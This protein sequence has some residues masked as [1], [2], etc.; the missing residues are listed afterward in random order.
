MQTLHRWFVLCLALSVFGLIRC[1]LED[2][3]LDQMDND[4]F[5]EIVYDS[6]FKTGSWQSAQARVAFNGIPANISQKG[7]MLAIEFRT[8]TDHFRLLCIEQVESYIEELNDG[9]EVKREMRLVRGR[10]VDY[11]DSEVF[12]YVRDSKFF[13]RVN[14]NGRE[15]HV[16]PIPAKKGRSLLHGVRARVYEINKLTDSMMRNS[17]K[18]RSSEESES[19]GSEEEQEAEGHRAEQMARALKGLNRGYNSF[20]DPDDT[21]RFVLNKPS[22][23]SRLF[24]QTVWDVKSYGQLAQDRKQLTWSEVVRENRVNLNISDAEKKT[25]VRYQMPARITS[26]FFICDMFGY[27]D[28]NFVEYMGSPE[29]AFNEIWVM[30]H[31]MNRYFFERLDFDAKDSLGQYRFRIWRMRVLQ[32]RG[33]TPTTIWLRLLEFS[34]SYRKLCGSILFTYNRFEMDLPTRIAASVQVWHD[35]AKHVRSGLCDF[36]ERN[37]TFIDG[38]KIYAQRVTNVTMYTNTMVVNTLGPDGPYP[39]FLAIIAMAREMLHL[40]GASYEEVQK[41]HCRGFLMDSLYEN[42]WKG[43]SASRCTIYSVR[44]MLDHVYSGCF[45]GVMSPRCGDMIREGDET[46]DCGEQEVCGI[47]EPCCDPKQCRRFSNCEI[48]STIWPPAFVFDRIGDVSDRYLNSDFKLNSANWPIRRYMGT[49][50]KFEAWPNKFYDKSP[51]KR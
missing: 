30:I 5:Q 46:C 3:R 7:K 39:R 48:K 16:E 47:V 22:G 23:R 29:A 8:K 13:G 38:S 14:M 2:F 36:L 45:D 17:R 27:A 41:S 9:K 37:V 33:R 49:T 25:M 4:V 19:K 1:A 12:G 31:S 6:D 15:L 34:S 44:K 42:N 32:E 51:N 21:R 26:N 24:G 18:R 35:D 10:S 43:F 40:L 28:I 11:L 20:L 50:P